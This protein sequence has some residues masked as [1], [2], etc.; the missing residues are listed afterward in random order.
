VNRPPANPNP[1]PGQP[2][3]QQPPRA[4]RGAFS[5]IEL[6][7]TLAVLTILALALTPILIRE[8]DRHAREAETRQLATLIGGLR[9]HILRTRSIP[10]ADTFAQAIATELGLQTAD[11]LLNP[12]RQP[13]VLLLD[14]AI[15]NSIPIPYSQTAAGLTSSVPL[16]SGILLVSSTSH[17]LPPG[18]V[19]GFA[20]S[21]AAFSN[22]WN[23]AE[24]TIPQG[25]SWTGSGHDL[26]IARLNLGTLFVP[27]ALNYETSFNGVTNLG[28]F[29]I[30][31]STTNSLPS[32]PTFISH[33]LVGSV[34]GLHHHAGTTNTIQARLVLQN[35]ASYFYQGGVWRGQAF[36]G[37]GMRPTSA[38]DLQAAY[39][40]FVAAPS[41]SMAQGSPQAS[42]VIVASA[43]TSFLQEYVAW[44]NNGYPASHKALDAAHDNLDQVTSDLLHRPTK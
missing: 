38:L 30:D 15:T 33:F 26:R 29:T 6:L 34:L 8:F 25:W 41:N 39:D 24:N 21:S 20:S 44:R 7:G 13:R 11:V 22:V 37:R 32:I 36:L 31:A 14:P 23:T 16:A 3:A 28:R 17:P 40:L 42:P 9:S 10:G 4:R 5:L 18:I 2:Q 12:R 43:M 1:N 27:L 19:S 35:P